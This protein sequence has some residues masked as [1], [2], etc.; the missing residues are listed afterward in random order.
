MEKTNSNRIFVYDIVRIIAI[1]AVIMIHCTSFY[2]KIFK[3]LSFEYTVG[4]I[5]ETISCMAV[6]L[7]VL[8]SGIFMLNENKELPVSKLAKKII[9]LF[10][11]LIGWSLFYAA[12]YH[13]NK[14]MHYFLFGHYHLWY[15]YMVIG[16][17]LI[18]PILRLF[19]KLKNMTYLYYLMIL[20]CVFQFIPNFIDIITFQTDNVDKFFKKFYMYPV[21]GFI[22]Y[23]I[24]GWLIHND[25]KNINKYKNA[26]YGLGI[27]CFIVMIMISEFFPNANSKIHKLIIHSF[28]FP[29]FWYSISVFIFIKNLVFKIESKITER[30]KKIVASISQL[31]FGVY[32]VHAFILTQ[33]KS[34]ILNEYCNITVNNTNPLLF[35]LLLYTGTVVFSY[36]VVYLI[37]KVKYLKQIVKL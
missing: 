27:G 18:T 9:K 34:N 30:V 6:Q 25:W 33:I 37:L 36:I 10:L 4:N 15:L 24:M 2:S 17:Y 3:P 26:I 31:T 22:S 5:L 20:A 19:V 32:L 12:V 7:F 35:V 16:L 8:L 29:V 28:S 23:Y 21:Y 1:L 14:L 13:P 11:L